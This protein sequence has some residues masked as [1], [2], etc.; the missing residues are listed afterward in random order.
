MRGH[1]CGRRLLRLLPA[2]RYS[3]SGAAERPAEK[4]ADRRGRGGSGLRRPHGFV[5][6][7]LPAGPAGVLLL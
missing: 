1:V 7:G 5:L 3:P 2:L 6:H 4:L